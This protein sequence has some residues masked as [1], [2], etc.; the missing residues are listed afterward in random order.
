MHRYTSTLLTTDTETLTTELEH[1]AEVVRQ[2]GFSALMAEYVDKFNEYLPTLLFA[3]LFA[4]FALL[5]ICLVMKISR[6]ALAKSKIDV[7]LHYFIGTLIKYLLLF[8]LVMAVITLMKLPTAP[9]VAALGAVGLA[10][11]LA[12][13]D[14]LANL[15]GGVFLLFNRPFKTGD[16]IEL[17]GVAGTVREIR[18]TYTVLQTTFNRNIFVPNGDFSKAT[19]TNYS[20]AD[21]RCMELTFGVKPDS[22]IARARAIILE[23]LHESELLLPNPAPVARVSDQTDAKVMITCM[24]WVSPTDLLEFKAFTIEKVREKLAREEL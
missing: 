2:E 14:S 23:T 15:A 19:I 9:I 21:T 13:R 16:Y 1:A 3:L 18:L 12:I 17:K 8:M 11:S 6:R 7:A 20:M 24:A 22:D 4:A 10:F 5:A